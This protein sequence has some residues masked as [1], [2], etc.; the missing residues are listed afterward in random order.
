MKIDIIE[1]TAGRLSVLANNILHGEKIGQVSRKQKKA[2]KF[3]QIK[4]NGS[5][6]KQK[7]SLI[8]HKIRQFFVKYF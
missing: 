6:L 4:K 8:N 1:I 2:D 5:I 7:L 3:L